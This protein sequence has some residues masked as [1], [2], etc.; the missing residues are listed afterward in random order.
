MK[1]IIFT[2][3]LLT[4]IRMHAQQSNPDCINGDAE[5]NNYAGWDTYAG[6]STNPQNLNAFT[7]VNDPARFGIQCGA[8]GGACSG[9]SGFGS[10]NML[11]NGIDQYGNFPLP[12]QGSYCFRIG[13]NGTG[14]TLGR[15]ASM[16]HYVFT[17]TNSNKIFKFRYAV[18]MQDGHPLGENPGVYM[19]MCKGNNIAP[20]GVPGNNASGWAL[21]NNTFRGVTAQASNPY[22]K[23]STVDPHIVYKSWQCV[24]YDL[25]A[26]IGQT[27]S[28]VF[29]AKDC[30]EG[31]HFGYAYLD[32][33][34]TNWPATAQMSLN[35]STFCNNGIHIKMNGSASVN[36]DRYYVEVAECDGSGNLIPNGDNANEW[37]LGQQPPASFDITNW[38]TGKGKNLKCNSYY[39]VKL[40][41]MNDCSPW[42][43]DSR[44]I[45]FTC[46]RINAG[47]DVVRCCN[48]DKQKCVA[49][50]SPSVA[51]LTYH[52]TSYPAGY[53]S[54]F[55]QNTVCPTSTT[56]YILTV[57]DAN[58][59]S[60]TDSIIVR[61]LNAKFDIAVTQLNASPTGCTA[62]DADRLYH[63]TINN[64]TCPGE[65]EYFATHYPVTNE[66][67]WT[68]FDTKTNSYMYPG[69][70]ANYTAPNRDG[71]L[72]CTVDN[73][74]AKITKSM[75]IKARPFYVTSFYAP[76]SFTPVNQDGLN[77]VFQVVDVGLNS[78]PLGV[79]P[80][81][82]IKAWRLKIYDRNGH[83]FVTIQKTPANN[84]CIK[85]GDIQWDGKDG[86]GQFVQ[87]D[88]YNYT[89]EVIYCGQSTWEYVHLQGSTYSPCAHWIWLFCDVHLPGWVSSI[90]VLQ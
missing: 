1:K 56:A 77:D 42:S 80:A 47:E 38:Y 33:L 76:D 58:G 45:Q 34:C 41:V 23:I 69:T 63:A 89:L 18:V 16:M 20:I 49:I 66:I 27:L 53:T 4:V 86:S 5:S 84:D 17:V 85:N 48:A 24:E 83:N 10:Q 65:D 37:F 72:F 19:F 22:F 40:A 8:G 88:V 60:V 54:S 25:S 82:G 78:P 3:C 75:S 87:L 2:L 29:C 57:T 13:H 11:V 26:Y 79:G 6:T 90:T 51:G 43:E 36:T 39:K 9:F 73:G 81:Y 44:V 12:N 52:W 21:F 30:T 28:F 68:F 61:Y 55:A 59:C 15:K 64:I 7:I 31:G 50:G 70:G 71:T 35:A 46:P 74:C 14:T 62:C 32:G 67:K